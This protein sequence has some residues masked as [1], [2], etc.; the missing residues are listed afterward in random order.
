LKP[1]DNG[2]KIRDKLE[3]KALGECELS[4]G[5]VKRANVGIGMGDGAC[6]VAMDAGNDRTGAV[7]GAFGI[8]FNLDDIETPGSDFRLR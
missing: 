6:E 5:E 2:G 4:V 7:V 8:A 1:N 3:E